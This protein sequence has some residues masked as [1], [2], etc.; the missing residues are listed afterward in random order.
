VIDR[1]TAPE[2]ARAA[3]DIDAHLICE[4]EP[5]IN[6]EF[7]AAHPVAPC[8]LSRERQGM[9][10]QVR[11]VLLEAANTYGSSRRR[12]NELRC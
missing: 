8:I 6:A 10:R 4:I 12:H 3:D 11:A 7:F 2:G 1:K 9:G 5:Y